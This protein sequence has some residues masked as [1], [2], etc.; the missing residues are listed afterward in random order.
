LLLCNIFGKY[1]TSR[2]GINHEQRKSLTGSPGQP[3]QITGPG[4]SVQAKFG[5]YLQDAK[6]SRSLSQTEEAVEREQI[7]S[8][9]QVLP[10][11]GVG[12]EKYRLSIAWKL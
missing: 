8:D 4:L 11:P 2:G 3:W 5:Q 7:S 6:N 12:L 1:S 10:T 9:E